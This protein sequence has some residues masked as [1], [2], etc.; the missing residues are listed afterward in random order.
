MRTIF[1][2]LVVVFAAA[3]SFAADLPLVTEV[4]QGS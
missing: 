2:S 3:T 1:S 4:E